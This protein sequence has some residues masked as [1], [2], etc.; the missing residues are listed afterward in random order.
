MSRVV[1]TGVASVE[2]PEA[3]GADTSSRY[4]VGEIIAD[5][6]QLLCLI[7]EG[8]MGAVWI[9]KN[10]ALDAQVALKLVRGDMT[11]AA[12]EDRFLTEARAAARLKHPAICRVFDFARTRH[13]QPFMVMELLQGETLG[14]VLDREIKLSSVQAVQILL[15]IV[16]GLGA[17]HARG[18][19]HR[20]LKPDNVYLAD[21]DGRLQPK[22]LDF[23]VAKLATSDVTSHRITQAGTVVGSP[24]YMAP[25]QARGVE[26]ID[27]RTDIWG[28]CVLLYEC[29]T[30]RVPFEDAN[31]NALLRHIIEDEMQSIVELGAGDDDLWAVMK[32]GLEK[33]RE[34]RYQSM[35]SLGEALAAWLMA[36]GVMEDLSGH[37][38]RAAWVDPLPVGRVSL[39][40]IRASA[41]PPAIAA[42]LAEAPTRRPPTASVVG[43]V[44]PIAQP[45][46]A[47]HRLVAVAAVVMACMMLLGYLMLRGGTAP[48]P[49]S[50][51]PTEGA[52]GSGQRGTP[53]TTTTT[54]AT[55]AE[56]ATASAQPMSAPTTE[57]TRPRLSKKAVLSAPSSTPSS[58]SSP[59]KAPTPAKPKGGYAEDL[60]F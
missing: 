13:D 18:V 41:T 52:H 19:I 5:K 21:A 16:D 35:R 39:A 33:D 36:R 32:K 28:L 46:A 12:N 58:I 57:A 20:D 54:T 15:P 31:Y 29:V 59:T 22:I 8:G 24:D 55:S 30:G 7:G 4:A 60:G 44:A 49:S 34:K 11:S 25:E 47:R 37:S 27:H 26:D 3:P 1:R 53:T 23:G 38:L 2:S 56:A 43:T 45:A 50:V 9:A 51:G 48:E 14:E 6:Y 40:S 17:A 10:L 42:Q